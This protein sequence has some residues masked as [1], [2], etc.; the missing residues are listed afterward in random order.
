VAD[1]EVVTM[2]GDELDVLLATWETGEALTNVSEERVRQ[3]EKW[4][5]QSIPDRS[6]DSWAGD[7]LAAESAERRANFWKAENDRRV[8]N[9]TLAWDGVLL[10]EVYEGL[11]ET[12]PVKLRAELVQIAAVAVAWVEDLDRKRDAEILERKIAFSNARADATFSVTAIPDP[13]YPGRPW[14]EDQARMEALS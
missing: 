7:E 2:I 1:T 13:S 14:T 10:E 8:A 12:D 11:A 5:V 4:G 3:V 9:G 6:T